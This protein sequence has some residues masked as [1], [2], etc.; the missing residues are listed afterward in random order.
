M[1]SQAR[2][3]FGDVASTEVRASL[4]AAAPAEATEHPAPATD[5]TG[6][7]PPPIPRTGITITKRVRID[8]VAA[9]L[10]RAWDALLAGDAASATEAY[11]AVLGHE[12]GNRDAHL[13]LAAVAGRAGR[14]DE[15]AGHYARILA[16][17]PAD[18]V[19]R[20]ALL[21]IDEQDPAQAE[22]RLKALLASEPRAAH[23]HFS[24]GA[25]YAAQSRWPEAQRSFFD[26]YRFDRGNADYAYNLAV[27]LDHL[28]QPR[29][30]LGFYREAL[31]LARS[32]PASFEAAA[33]L[34][35]IRDLDPQSVPAPGPVRPTSEADVSAPARSIR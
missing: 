14:W 11:R 19:A 13:G 16:S 28:S 35:R 33:V 34:R 3:A 4:E 9:S 23:L 17:H 10:A 1:S 2:V 27:S 26:A 31:F 21:A 25:L 5:R 8:H 22:S 18:T 29:S 15:A 32:R 12:P 7:E 24:L 20:A 6:T 30:A